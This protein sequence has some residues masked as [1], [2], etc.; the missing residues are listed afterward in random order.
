MVAVLV[1]K[2]VITDRGALGCKPCSID[3]CKNETNCLLG[4]S[5][6]VCNCCTKCFRVSGQTCGGIG[7]VVGRCGAGLRCNL[8][9]ASFNN[10]IG[11]CVK[12]LTPT[13]VPPQRLLTK[14]PFLGA[15]IPDAGNFGQELAVV[16]ETIPGVARTKIIDK[17]EVGRQNLSEDNA[18]YFVHPNGMWRVDPVELLNDIHDNASVKDDMDSKRERNHAVAQE[19][20]EIVNQ[21]SVKDTLSDVSPA[22]I[23]VAISGA[24]FFG[25]VALLLLPHKSSKVSN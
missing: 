25:L 4:S 18:K 15:G 14:A 24:V 3:D 6:D 17:S 23:F 19:H 12:A 11:Y 7:Y 2:A 16:R 5:V 21:G 13:I 1:C 10:P 9:Q 22:V 8:A 20:Q